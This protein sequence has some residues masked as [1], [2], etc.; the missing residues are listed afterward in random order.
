MS[1]PS[2]S[3][4]RAV[5]ANIGGIAA[6]AVR[7]A[8]GQF[9]CNCSRGDVSRADAHL[10]AAAPDLLAAARVALVA[11]G[12]AGDPCNQNARDALTGAVTRAEAGR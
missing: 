10:I 1:A 5:P 9:V 12:S 7:D 4:W 6:Y 8:D 11:L 2:P 3:P